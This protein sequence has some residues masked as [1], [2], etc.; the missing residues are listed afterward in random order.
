MDFSFGIIT[1]NNNYLNDII[2][3]IY[4][5]NIENFEIILIG[6]SNIKEDNIKN[7]SFDESKKNNWITKKK[8][9]ITENSSYDNIVFLHDYI[10]FDDNWYKGFLKFGNNWDICM[11]II[12]N[13]DGSRFRDWCLWYY[14]IIQIV[15]EI[16]QT[17]ELLLPY[18]VLNLSKIMYISGSYWIAKK[19]VMQEF[20]LNED[21]VWDE[22]EDVEWSKRVREKYN[23]S[24]NQ[25]SK[26]KCLKQKIIDFNL[27]KNETIQK[28][29]SIIC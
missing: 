27:C 28:I 6:N 23:F 18:D 1:N 4:K 26:V 16:K 29:N 24:M 25:N 13:A 19:R 5:Q 20:P 7:I 9:L 17:N 22:S 14:D 12:E 8:N 15:P 21:L 11:N 10:I 3:S 2:N